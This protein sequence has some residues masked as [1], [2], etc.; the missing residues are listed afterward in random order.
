MT[1]MNVT[2]AGS[3]GAATGPRRPR[4][5]APRR[6]PRCPSFDK[7]TFLKLL[8]A[9]LKYQDPTNPTDA[10]QFMSQTAQFTMVEKL[11]ALSTLD[12]Q[13]LDASRR[14]PPRRSSAGR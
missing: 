1:G 6:P 5:P 9:Q 10:T 12:Q 14:S 7:D 3:A 4:R 8:V 13:V 11:D 2:G